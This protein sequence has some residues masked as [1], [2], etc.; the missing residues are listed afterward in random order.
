[1]EIAVIGILMLATFGV[2]LF[3]LYTMT[4]TGEQARR[5]SNKLMMWRVGLQGLTLCVL[6]LFAFISHHQR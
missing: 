5:T 1:M 4:R 6:A 3:G 2:L